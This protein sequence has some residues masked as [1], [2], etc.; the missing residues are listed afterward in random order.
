MI[1]IFLTGD[2]HIGRRYSS[3]KRGEEIAQI[4]LS[5]LENVVRIA[6][7]EECHLIVVA[8]DLF[9]RTTQITQKIIREVIGYLAEFHGTVIVMPGNHDYCDK[10]IKLWDDFCQFAAVCG[11]IIV[12]NECREYEIHDVNGENVVC[13]PAPC[14]KKHSDT[15]QLHWIRQQEIPLDDSYRIGIAHGALEG[16]SLDKEG[17]YFPMS[18]EELLEI[19]VDIWLLGHSHVMYP[20]TL[21]E[22]EYREDYRIFNAGTHAQTDVHC[23]TEGYGIV[24]ELEGSGENKTRRAKKCKT[25]QLRFYREHIVVEGEE[26]AQSGVLRETIKK[27][28]SKYEENS[29]VDLVISGTVSE[30]EY[31]DRH[32]IYEELLSHFFEYVPPKDDMLSVCLS[33][34]KIKECYIENSL[35]ARALMQ[36][37]SQPK[38][39][40]MLYEL[41]EDVRKKG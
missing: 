31:R 9:D 25:G 13:Y 18:T 30:T 6:N 17:R 1:K 29:V 26:K 32:A 11:N 7:K 41:M 16:V 5:S 12:M 22:D 4:R 27:T 15:N 21:V 23:H 10:N 38:E 40:Q 20:P 37:I 24:I 3:H 36:L 2:N 34:Q 14:Q 28:I 19:P 8:G 39:A 33:E 35:P